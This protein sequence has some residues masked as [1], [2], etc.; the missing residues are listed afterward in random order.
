MSSAPRPTDKQRTDSGQ[1]SAGCRLS[2]QEVALRNRIPPRKLL[3][4]V[5]DEL[6]F[7]G[8][9]ENGPFEVVL[10]HLGLQARRDVG[11]ARTTYSVFDPVALVRWFRQA[12]VLR[13]E[14]ADAHSLAALIDYLFKSVPQERITPKVRQAAI[15]WSQTLRPR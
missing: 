7:E 3:R 14:P 1:S 4:R 15:H 5:A 8:Q 2:V 11:A 10:R 9:P 12:D 6:R 13:L